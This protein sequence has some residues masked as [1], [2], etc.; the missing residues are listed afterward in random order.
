M[1]VRTSVIFVIG[2]PASRECSRTKASL[3]G[4][5]DAKRPVSRDEGLRPLHFPGKVGERIVERC[6]KILK[7]RMGEATNI[8]YVTFDQITFHGF[9]RA[10]LTSGFVGRQQVRVHFNHAVSLLAPR[11]PQRRHEMREEAFVQFVLQAFGNS[12]IGGARTP[13]SHSDHR[14]FPFQNRGFGEYPGVRLSGQS[15]EALIA[16]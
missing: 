1:T 8:R 6:G 16:S 9:S 15:A 11:L 13:V 7:L 5:V 2:N 4:K 10:A 12:S 14:V 3:F